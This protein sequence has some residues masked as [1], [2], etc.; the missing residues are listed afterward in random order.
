MLKRVLGPVLGAVSL[1]AL[2]TALPGAASA[3]SAILQQPSLSASQ[4]AFVYGGDIWTVPRAGGRA[5]RL[6]VGVGVESAPVFSPDGR[7]IAF[8]GE[9]DGNV[10]V[11]TV[12]VSGGLPRRVTYHPT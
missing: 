7:T 6:T 3:Q 11:Y 9:Y 5:V 2:A 10:D 1:A 12:P 8:T 4:I